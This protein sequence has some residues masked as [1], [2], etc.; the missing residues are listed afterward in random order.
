MS[1]P[2]AVYQNQ[3]RR[4]IL[5]SD[6]QQLRCLQQ[7][8]DPLYEHLT[9]IGSQSRANPL[10]MNDVK[11]LY[12][13]GGVG[14][15]KTYMMDLFRENLPSDIDCCRMHFHAFMKDVHRYLH[16][17]RMEGKTS[18]IAHAVQNVIKNANVLCFDEMMVTDVAD[19]MIL[20]RIFKHLYTRGLCL[21]TTS[22]R[23][24]QSLY[25]NGLNREQF[26]PFI[27]LLSERCKVFNMDADVD[28]RTSLGGGS[29]ASD[30][31]YFY[32][33]ND[34]KQ[35]AKFEEKFRS[36]MKGKKVAKATIRSDFKREVTIPQA[37]PSLKVC[38]FTF[39]ELF[40]QERNAVDYETISQKF[41][42]IFIENFPKLSIKQSNE[43][44]RM[45]NALDIFYQNSVKLIILA[46]AQPQELC[47]ED[48]SKDDP[49]DLLGLRN[50]MMREMYSEEFQIF[51]TED[52][53]FMIKRALSR[54]TE[55][56]SPKYMQE[57]WKGTG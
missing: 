10:L 43:V 34:A 18:D 48:S 51:N 15:G 31:I 12:L 4:K 19:A 57:K 42:T 30:D 24:P 20:K 21:V 16:K 38:R 53:Q 56:K 1:L 9:T 37:V 36:L 14:C 50:P 44:R 27:D 40:C 7:C 17:S 45:I 13:W 41:H 5:K 25:Q 35:R 29:S 6:A 52:E 32:P 8:F 2:S 47:L 11:G 55:M 46:D 54:L 22:N 49:Y 39:G 23:A 26:L 33:S 28:Y 3:V